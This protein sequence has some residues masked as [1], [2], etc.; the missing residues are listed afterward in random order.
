[1]WCLSEDTIPSFPKSVQY[2]PLPSYEEALSMPAADSSN[3]A[4]ESGG[5]GVSSAS[6]VVCN[7]LQWLTDFTQLARRL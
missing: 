6:F 4:G 5:G 1:M 3:V 2:P 7:H